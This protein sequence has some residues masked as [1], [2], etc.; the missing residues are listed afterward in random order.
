MLN[1]HD[2]IKQIHLASKLKKQVSL[3]GFNHAQKHLPPIVFYW[4]LTGCCYALVCAAV[5]CC[6][7]S[8]FFPGCVFPVLLVSVF[9]PSLTTLPNHSHVSHLCLTIPAPFLYLSP[10]PVLQGRLQTYAFVEIILYKVVQSMWVWTQQLPF[11]HHSV[12]MMAW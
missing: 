4:L 2:K 12:Q 1:F 10:P 7:V 8:I 9:S 11:I 6:D 5:C 3:D